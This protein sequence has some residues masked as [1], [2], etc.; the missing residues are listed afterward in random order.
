[1]VHALEPPPLSL[2]A[3]LLRAAGVGGSFELTSCLGI[4]TCSVWA[5]SVGRQQF[6]VRQ[7]LDGNAQL[8]HKEAYLSEL[9]RRNHVPAPEV[10][11]VVCNEQGVATLSTLLPGVQFATV[12]KHVSGESQFSAW[13]EVAT[14]LRLVHE[15]ELP[16]SGEIIVDPIDPFLSRRV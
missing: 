4:S 9:L 1:M 10:L 15:I 13:K 6:V 2:I 7:R 16:V 11:A 3:A 14:T 5:L 8:A 12:L